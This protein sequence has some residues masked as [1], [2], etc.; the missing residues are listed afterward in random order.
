MTGD[1]KSAQAPVTFY[2][3]V[4]MFGVSAASMGPWLE[5]NGPKKAL[6]L[7]S[8]LFFFGNLLSS[9]A[10]YLK[11][12]W[13]LYI[14]YGVIGGFG[15]G[16]GYISPVSPLQKWFPHKRGLA[17]GLAVCGFGAG[18]IAIGKVILPLIHS[19]G[20]SLTFV[21]L[22]SCYF[23]A[24]VSVALLFRI[25][26]PGYSANSSSVDSIEKT[27]QPEIKLTLIES[28]KSY[29][30]LL[31]YIMFFANA[32]FGL[33]SFYISFILSNILTNIEHPILGSNFEIIK[34]D[35]TTIFKEPG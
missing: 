11:A 6:I 22:G 32:L 17:A 21:V 23:I 3:A 13:L 9:L 31:L 34:Y 25:P 1:P 19:V 28:I 30:F 35:H 10:I 8:S 29:D 20:L 24:M 18:S 12:I 5:R 15:L 16:L 33:V 26:P 14:G 4:G 2:I 7:S 27:S